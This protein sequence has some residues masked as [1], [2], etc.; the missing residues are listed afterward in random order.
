MKTPLALMVCLMLFLLFL[1]GCRAGVYES[2][3]CPDEASL[4]DDVCVTTASD[5][6]HCGG[7]R[8]A[9]ESGQT[10]ESGSCVGSADGSGGGSGSGGGNAG[11][12]GDSASGGSSSTGGQ[13]ATGG[14]AG[15][16]GSPEVPVTGCAQPISLAPTSGSTVV[17]TGTKESCTE[18]ALDTAVAQGGV[19]TFNCGAEPHT[20]AVTKE[21]AIRLDRDTVIDGGGTIT[22][23]AGKRSRIFRM[24]SGNWLVNT[25]TLV[26]QRLTLKN[27]KPDPGTYVPQSST[28]PNCAYGYDNTSAGGAVAV[29]DSTLHV[30]D[31]TFLDNESA[32][33]GPDVGGGAIAVFGSLQGLTVVN[34]RFIG[35]SASN[36]GAVYMLFAKGT[37]VDTLFENNRATGFGMNY[38]GGKAAGCPGIGHENQGGAG[39]NGGAVGADG[40]NTETL[41]CGSVFRGNKAN[42]LGTVFRT[43][44]IAYERVVFEKTTFE[45]NTARGGAAGY[46]QDCDLIVNASTFTNNMAGK[47]VAG[48][49]TDWGLG[50][51]FMVPNTTYSIVNSTFHGNS[52][53]TDG[54]LAG[55]P[56]SIK[57]STFSD[58]TPNAWGSGSFTVTNNVFLNNACN[59]SASG[60]NNLQ[61]PSTGTGCVSGITRAD[62]L[63]GVLAD[64]GGPTKTMLPATGSPAIG[65]GR[66][67]PNVDQRGE[68]RNTG[69]CAAGAVEP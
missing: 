15:T 7:C 49:N 9:C 19:I 32:E 39:G 16:G 4:C 27:A 22:L 68:A 24:W 1:V 25:R 23:D 28:N 54:A 18:A 51:A 34:S 61:W 20:I 8:R 44:N 66:E 21:K 26:L 67:C 30:I 36:H 46:I 38:A 53:P 55:A 64:N 48:E 50:G 5:P 52:A 45:S 14:T 60:S 47:N 6:N 43:P 41:F 33:I 37:F 56:G 35:N 12:G 40:P 57:N 3:V 13:S 42:E 65:V 69:S 58:N 31:C 62:P 59:S 29:R 63:L 17:G 11:T 2:S 10:C